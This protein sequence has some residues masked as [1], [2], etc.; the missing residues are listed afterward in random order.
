M[1]EARDTV[2]LVADIGGTNARFAWAVDR[3]P[4][5]VVRLRVADH[6]TFDAALGDALAELPDAA[7][8]IDVAIAAAGPVRDRRVALTNASWTID[9]AALERRPDI[10]RA[11]LTNDF[12]AVAMALPRLA[13]G[14][15][16]LIDDV[17]PYDG[18]PLPMLVLGPGTGLGV[19]LSVPGDGG[20]WIP[21]A[22]EGGHVEL[23]T[24]V[25]PPEI[26]DAVRRMAG[27]PLVA[28]D[29]LSGTGL[30]R[31]HEA[32]GGEPIAKSSAVVT[33]AREGDPTARAAV[34]SFIGALGAVAGDAVLQTGGFGGVFIAGGVIRGIAEAS[35]F[36]GAALRHA[37]VHKKSYRDMLAGIPIA[38][39]THKDP[40]LLGLAAADLG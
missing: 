28:E 9:A 16:A 35:L 15:R 7:G 10:R 6:E 24:S 32:H 22:T 13:P 3:R 17:P 14:D 36:D 20:S 40:A 38:R 19:A 39:I 8:P 29:I 21:V 25:L 31:L 1:S 37:F 27:E 5:E 12:Q 18:P 30:L 4:G 11:A 26:A 2:R 23:G 34:R 33:A